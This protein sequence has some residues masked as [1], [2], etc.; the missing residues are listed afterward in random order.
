MLE[1]ELKVKIDIARQKETFKGLLI[2][3]GGTQWQTQS[4]SFPSSADLPND[5]DPVV[6]DEDVVPKN[7]HIYSIDN[8]MS[9]VAPLPPNG[10][11]MTYRGNFLEYVR[12]DVGDGASRPNAYIDNNGVI[13]NAANTGSRASAKEPWLTRMWAVTSAGAFVLQ[14]GNDSNGNT[15]R[16]FINKGNHEKLTKP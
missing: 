11:H 16:N 4:S 2:G 7:K 9:V 15:I 12:I 8:P 13:Q 1:N 6:V 5:D 3:G 14:A 10:T